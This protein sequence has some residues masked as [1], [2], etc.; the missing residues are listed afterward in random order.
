M[1]ILF[2]SD[3]FARARA[4]NSKAVPKP[5]TVFSWVNDIIARKLAREPL[6]LP[7][8]AQAMEAWVHAK[9]SDMDQNFTERRRIATKQ[10]SLD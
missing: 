9:E 5:E 1:V 4:R 7:T 2:R 6:M 8:T 3:V 10:N